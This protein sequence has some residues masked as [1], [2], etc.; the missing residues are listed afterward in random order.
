LTDLPS[1]SSQDVFLPGSAS[2]AALLFEASELFDKK[3]PKADEN[4]RS[5]RSELVAA[6]DGCIDAA[7]REFEVF[8]QK[9]LLKVSP[10]RVEL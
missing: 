7:G 10:M 9:E 4:I 6:V 3:N 1:E 8:W 2:P 5:I